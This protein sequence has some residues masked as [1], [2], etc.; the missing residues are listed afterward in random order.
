MLREDN[1]LRVA[2]CNPNI[3][4]GD[5]KHNMDEV[6]RCI[7]EADKQEVSVLVFPELTMTGYSIGDLFSQTLLTDSVLSHLS[8]F[9]VSDYELVPEGM[10]VV[11]G[12]PI[13]AGGKLYNSA[14][15]ISSDGIEGIVPKS[16]LP[17][18]SEFYE[19]RY[20][21]EALDS[22]LI[23]YIGGKEVVISKN[24]LFKSGKATIGIEICEDLWVANPPSTSHALAGANIILNLSS[25]NELIGKKEYRTELVKNQSARLMCGYVYSNSG[26][27]E[28]TTDVVYS[29]HSLICENGS[30]LSES[31]LFSDEL[32][33]INEIDLDKLDFERRK[34]TSFRTNSAD[35]Y[36]IKY[37]DLQ[38]Y[39]GELSR[40]LEK[41]PFVPSNESKLKERC[42]L[43]LSIQTEGLRKRV[44]FTKSKHIVLGLSGG[45]D[46]TLALLV[47]VRAMDKL[48][49]PRTDIIAVSMPCFGTTKRTKSN[50]QK[51]AESFGVTF[52]EIDITKA[53]LQHF[54]DIGQDKNEFNITFENSQAR[55]RTQ[56]LMDIANKNGGFV[57]GTGDMSELALGWCTFNG[58]HMSMYGVNSSIPKTLVKFL[59]KTEADNMSESELKSVLYDILDTPVSPE[60][61]PT[62]KDGNLKQVTED[63]V[64]PYVLHDF[65]LYHMLRNGYK[66]SKVYRLAVE[67][68]KTDFDSQTIYNWI[69]KFYI[70]FFQQQ[71]KRNAMP[72]GPKVGSVA[73]SPRGDWRMPSDALVNLWLEDLKNIK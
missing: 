60:L 33:L 38:L 50:A 70:R 20:F 34:N 23:T 24:L 4:L 5:V 16:F 32:L 40:K 45:L 14:V 52:K 12:A 11:V 47:M 49:R 36:T 42:E 51:L 17:N 3:K 63:S 28:S 53:V 39:N 19:M 55:E 62:D 6:L 25:S 65:F 31:P 64:G 7:R 44:D 27:F 56:V 67:A 57:V 41:Y 66:P 9:S 59:V 13:S 58:D 30:L 2:T 29:G 37:V 54:E 61:L 69:G 71:F 48:K 35:G 8:A 46:S 72:D 10:L 15:V 43:I 26:T 1:Y 22:D 68:F 21:A 73:L 18:Y